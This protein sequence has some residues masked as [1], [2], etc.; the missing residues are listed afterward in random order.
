MVS[1]VGYRTPEPDHP[2]HYGLPSPYLTIIFSLDDGVESASDLHALSATRPDPIVAAGLHT[3]TSYVLERRGQAGI[4][5]AVHPLASRALFGLPAAELSVSEYDG[6]QVLGRGAVSVQQRLTETS[7]W[8]TAFR[9][10]GDHLT[11]SLDRRQVTVRSELR[12]AWHLLEASGGLCPIERVAEAVGLTPRHLGTLFQ[13][14]VGRSPKT[15]AQLFRFQAAVVG[16][17]A[18][19]A[20]S[21]RVDLAAVAAG[22][23]YADQSHLTRDFRQ[24][25][26]VPPTRWITEEFRNLQDHSGPPRAES[27]P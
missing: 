27:V 24:R 8:S 23:G 9:T 26:G 13:R 12:H 14:E 20:R 21:G 1:A 22:A 16:V 6:R 19:L 2:V 18:Q 5:L 10:L 17:R 3:R 11:G 15:V 4:Q 7:T 25:V